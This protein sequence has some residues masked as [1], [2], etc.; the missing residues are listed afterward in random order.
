ML[1]ILSLKS[2]PRLSLLPIGKRGKKRT[3]RHPQEP[4]GD[5]GLLECE[6]GDSA[7]GEQKEREMERITA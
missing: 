2:P 5:T 3:G 7:Y 1:N 6:E 4:Y